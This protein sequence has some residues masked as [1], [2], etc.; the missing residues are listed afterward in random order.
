MSSEESDD[1]PLAVLAAAKR[2][3]PEKEPD[4]TVQESNFIYEPK[5]KRKR[6]KIKKT[7][8]SPFKKLPLT[9]KLSRKF[10]EV[11]S[12]PVV[13][14]P[15]DVWLYLKDFNP[16]APYSCLLCSEWFISKAKVIIHYVLNHKKDFCGICRLVGW[17]FLLE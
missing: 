8:E 1:E 3:N 12:P 5:K 6:V 11:L 4:K 14:R 9:F 2:L 7:P 10:K 17:N 13:E 15:A 16:T